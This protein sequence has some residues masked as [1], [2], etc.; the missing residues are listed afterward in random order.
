[1][2]D[3]EHPT[4]DADLRAHA[5]ELLVRA[6]SLD[7][8]G[9][10]EARRVV[11]AMR[12]LHLLPDTLL[13]EEGDAVDNDYLALV[14]DGQVRVVTS[15]SESGNDEVVMSIVG[16]GGLIGEMGVIDGGARSASCTTL[17]EVKLGVLSRAALLELVAA[18]PAAAA[19]LLLALSAGLARRLREGNRR[20]R[21]MSQ[22]TRALQL[23]L[24]ASHAVNR[25]L[26]DA[27][28]K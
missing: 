28:K 3:L 12:P 6:A 18:H 19:R 25:R 2:D 15:A 13:F 21:T 22:L 27:G 17:T 10:D 9:A 24:D 14:L 16:P 26:L 8:L 20:L 11:D 4:P 1:M 5:I 23:E 7:G